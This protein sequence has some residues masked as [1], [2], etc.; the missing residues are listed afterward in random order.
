MFVHA[1]PSCFSLHPAASV[2]HFFQAQSLGRGGRSGLASVPCFYDGRDVFGPEFSFSDFQ[3]GSC[4]D[5]DHV[6]KEAGSVEVKVDIASFADDVDPVD[7]PDGGFL[8]VGV[9]A[10]TFIV[11]LAG[12]VF[13]RFLH[14]FHIGTVIQDS[15]VFSLEDGLYRS[16]EAGVAVE[17]SDCFIPGMEAG[18]RFSYI[19]DCY[20]L[21]KIAVHVIPD[22]VR[23]HGDIQMDIGHHCFCV[24]AGIGSSRAG[25]RNTAAA[26]AGEDLFQSSLDGVPV[27]LVFPA[28]I[29]AAVITDCHFIIL[30]HNSLFA[31]MFRR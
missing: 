5:P 18:R 15:H 23:A 21:R 6:L 25:Y 20:V 3:Q 13:R 11:Q 26:H 31:A 17:L 19:P 22:L 24:D 29:P 16:V 12:H 14:S 27:R 30:F 1:R 28:V 4:H 8:H 10:E 7:D 2:V 9:S